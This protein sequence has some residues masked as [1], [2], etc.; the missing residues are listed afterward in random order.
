MTGAVVVAASGII[1]HDGALLLVQRGVAP[2]QGKWAVPGGRVE[3]GET[4]RAAVAR[5]VREETG[6]TVT[7][8]EFAGWVERIGEEGTHFV[9]LDFFAQPE[10]PGQTLVPGDD[11][12]DAM[13]VPIADIPAF[14][15]VDGLLEFL[16][17]IGSLDPW[18]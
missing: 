11:A 8:G 2:G 13:W 1:V 12:A 14:D 15:L 7:V 10:P 18:P 6:I 4:L 16:V 5:E 17:S 3:F 9:I